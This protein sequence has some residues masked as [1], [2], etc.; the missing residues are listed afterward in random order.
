MS[1]TGFAR[2]HPALQHHIVNTLGW[3]DLR[4][5]QQA[6]IDPLLD[7]ANL[8]AVAP[9]AAGKT[10]A[11]ALPLLSAM[12]EQSW[13]GLSVLYVCPLRALLNNL[14][15]RIGDYCQM[16]G[17][18]AGLWHGDVRGG[19]RGRI[20]EDPPDV[21]LTT[22]ESL[23]VML[24][25][26]K[27]D[28]ERL[29]A[30]VRAVVVDEIHAFGGDD[31]GW[32]LL[33]VLERIARV[34]GRDLQRIGL[35]ATVGEPASLLRWLCGSSD[36][37]SLVVAPDSDR[38]AAPELTL[39][40][41]G[42][43]RNAAHVISQ[44]H[45]GEK[46]LVFCDSRARV[47]QL[48]VE[49]RERQVNTFVSHSSLALDERRRAEDAF[50]QARDCVIVATSTLELG[51][52]VGD[53][54]R[55]VQIDAPG[56]VASFL[57]R[58]GRAGR[59]AGTVRNMLFLTT[60][61]ELTALTA[62]GLLALHATGYVEPVVA[63]PMPWHLLAQQ[64]LALVLQR[65]GIGRNLW[66]EELRRLPEFA[67]AIDAGV[68]DAVVA[69]LV[70]EGMLHDDQGMLSIGPAGEK[71]YGYRHFIELTSAFTTDP[72]FVARHGA[73][74]IGYLH[75]IG[76]LTP[77]KHYATVL[78]AGRAWD[79]VGIDWGRHT[80]AVIPSGTGG[81]SRWMGSA[82][83]LSGEL[84]RAMRDVLTGTDP[85]GVTLSKRA[86]ATLAEL[87]ADAPWAEPG[88]TTVVRDAGKTHWWTFAGLRANAALHAALGPLLVAGPQPDNLRIELDLG[89]DLQQLSRRL[90]DLDAEQ[91]A[92]SPLAEQLADELK[93]SD[94]LPAGLALRIADARLADPP[95]VHACLAEPR[96]GWNGG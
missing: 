30:G 38:P 66:A 92:P 26:R 58:L 80:V 43:L 78:L 17:R 2:L 81:R 79:I 33:A 53:L 32:H 96:R 47:E 74:E 19:A 45:R 25:S 82:Q 49:L 23:E 59:R 11:A 91:L 16:V 41:V 83:P 18:R 85:D 39:D 35:S 6:T 22:P 65:G 48:A 28:H 88:T 13:Q 20:L 55:V 64:L 72:L 40:H 8:V 56:T 60:T 68:G 27:V 69:H 94:C 7:G 93:F 3:R 90:A 42:S 57:Q 67:A 31:R 70:A 44:L 1:D 37:P 21:L 63:P 36:R 62:A 12:L 71:A 52:D 73:T 77:D 14:Y 50:A 4:P 61:S 9:T 76:L 87:R 75:P 5:L 84:C 10:E 46:R 86:V 95:S 29:F 15:G 54:D 24:I 34:A 51:I 89:V